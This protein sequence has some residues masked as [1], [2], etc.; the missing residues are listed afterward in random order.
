MT[1]VLELRG[2]TLQ[3]VDRIKA[4][5]AKSHPRSKDLFG[6]AAGT[7]AGGTS[8]NFRSSSPF[9][10]YWAHGE[11]P[12]IWD[13]DGRP[14]VDYYLNG[15]AAIIGHGDPRIADAIRAY[16]SGVGGAMNTELELLWGERIK[17]LYPAA[18]LV[19]FTGS[20]SD[21]TTLAFRLVRAFT[22][23][24]RILRFERAYHG[25]HDHS[26]IGNVAPF[27]K[28]PG[29]IP[30]GEGKFVVTASLDDG[31]ERARMLLESGD[32]A[33]MIV[34]PSGA[35]M[36]MVPLDSDTLV[37]A[38][39]LAR[40]FEIPFICDENVTGFRWAPGGIQQQLALDP[41]LTLLGK[42]A[43]GGFPGGVIAGK[44][45]II[46]QIARGVR[47][48]VNHSGTYNGH[49]ITA[50]AAI[51]MIDAVKDGSVQR[52][53]T[54]FAYE[55]RTEL[56]RLLSDLGVVGFAYGPES[57]HWVYLHPADAPPIPL[58]PGK[59]NFSVVRPEMLTGIPLEITEAFHCALCDQG[60]FNSI[61]NGGFTSAVHGPEELSA[62]VHAYRAVLAEFQ[63]RHIVASV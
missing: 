11:G 52:A 32:I 48:P 56:N 6:R 36:G 16:D 53:A 41:D 33:G 58:T 57:T 20:G 3:Q 21:S 27:D 50:A 22:G 19:R 26:A 35:G 8:H 28:A 49:P 2:S 54:A 40:E 12:R 38:R 17:E 10:L 14:Y 60:V 25:W 18:D 45:A 59:P 7:L 39:A 24:D 13:I 9:P 4:R 29:G 31:F 43:T 61:F 47:S 63:Q 30:Q 46:E 34:E 1:A 62:T 44:A 51:A 5:F 15:C 55:L 37:A 23:R 42:I